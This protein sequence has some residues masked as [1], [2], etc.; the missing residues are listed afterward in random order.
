[1]FHR[2]PRVCERHP[3][4][5]MPHS[6]TVT[7][8]PS[9]FNHE[10]PGLVFHRHPAMVIA[11]TAPAM[12]DWVVM[13]EPTTTTT[14]RTA[15]C[16]KH[17][18][19]PRSQFR[20]R[21]GATGN[22]TLPGERHQTG[23]CRAELA[24][25]SPEAADDPVNNSDPSGLRPA[26]PGVARLLP[27]GSGTVGLCL[28]L[29]AGWGPFGTVSGCFALVG[30]HPTFIGTAGG[31]GSSPTASAS[32]GLLVSNATNPNSLRGAF[33]GG[34]GSGDLGLSVGGEGSVGNDNCNRTIWQGQ[35][36]VGIGLDL[37]IP[38]ETHGTVTDTWTWSP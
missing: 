35:A 38:F 29:S 18:F 16:S 32:L 1:V 6:P 7:M 17:A 20:P 11:I 8:S 5:R 37:P 4:L 21:N 2:H 12:G 22:V 27:K 23:F 25:D 13:A 10:P 24:S 28:N 30:G 3:R 33:A 15:H 26:G 19:A 36:S 14:R 34:G 31:G 9:W